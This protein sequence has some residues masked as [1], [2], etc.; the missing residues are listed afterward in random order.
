MFGWH[1]WEDILPAIIKARAPAM[2]V[3]RVLMITTG[4][5]LYL[6]PVATGSIVG[7]KLI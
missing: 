1:W 5:S 7:I 2:V 4:K 6:R 3:S